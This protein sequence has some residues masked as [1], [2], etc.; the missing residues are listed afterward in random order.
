[1]NAIKTNSFRDICIPN[2]GLV[3]LDVD[4]TVIHFKEMGRSWWAVREAELTALH[5]PVKGRELV[6][7]EWVRGAYIYSP[8]LTDPEEFPLFLHRVFDAQAH[9]IFLTARS[10]EL[11]D[12][13][14]FQLTRWGVT[15]E[16]E[17]IYFA[18]D[19]GV[20]LKAIV[21]SQGFTDI[22]FVDDMEHNC[23]SVYKEIGGDTNLCIYHFTKCTPLP[24]S[25]S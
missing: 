2:N 15:V 23:E 10:A 18:R 12:L 17:N 20:A 14:E 25:S 16:S 22:V 3:V 7:N 1:M 24:S 9:I 6:M 4:D 13:T 8:V 21:Q 19:K 11:R 5:G